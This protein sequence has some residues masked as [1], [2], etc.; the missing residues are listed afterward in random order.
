[1]KP[2][3]QLVLL[4]IACASGA[5]SAAVD[6]WPIDAFGT[7]D[8][9][10]LA[11]IAY[12][13][14]SDGTKARIRSY[15]RDAAKNT[16]AGLIAQGWLSGYDGDTESQLEAYRDCAHRFPT[17]LPCLGNLA[18]T[19]KDPG[20]KQK[21]L[22]AI[23]DQAPEF[24]D[25]TA[26][27]GM[28][29]LLLDDRGDPTAAAALL[30]A[31]EQTNPGHA[32]FDFIRGLQA[33]HS[34]HNNEKAALYFRKAI[35]KRQLR[36][37]EVLRRLIELET[38]PL[39]EGAG[40][41]LALALS[42]VGDY[43][44]AGGGTDRAPLYYLLQRFASGPHTWNQRELILEL[45]WLTTGNKG[46]AEWEPEIL[47]FVEPG[48]WVDHSELA[49]RIS[50]EIEA[51]GHQSGEQLLW[52]SQVAL[53]RDRDFR[54]AARLARTGLADLQTEKQRRTS[55]T[56]LMS[57]FQIMNRCDVA[58]ELAKYFLS[59]Y[60]PSKGFY[61]Q[62]FEV[63]L[64]VG[65]LAEAAASLA[66][67][68]DLGETDNSV[69]RDDEFRLAVARA[70]RKP[71]L[72]PVADRRPAG[73]PSTNALALSP[74]GSMLAIG[75]DPIRLVDTRT[76]NLIGNLGQGTLYRFTPNGQHLVVLGARGLTV[77]ETA[78]G[79]SVG[80][81][82]HTDSQ[83][84]RGFA[85]GPDGQRLVVTDYRG[86]LFRYRLP[87]LELETI[88]QICPSP[89]AAY[90]AWL[91][92]G[93]IVTASATEDLVRRW[94]PETLA[95]RGTL[96]GVDWVHVLEA[97]PSG[98][99]LAAGDNSSVLHIWDTQ[100]SEPW[101]HTA[102]P[103]TFAGQI[104]F[105]PNE[106]RLIANQWNGSGIAVAVSPRGGYPQALPEGINA[107]HAYS[108][109]GLTVYR[110][111]GGLQKL[112][113][114]TLD[115]ILP[116][117]T[118]PAGPA[119]Y[120]SIRA[121]PELGVYAVAQADRTEFRSLTDD[122]WVRTVAARLEPD[123]IAQTP[124]RFAGALAGRYYVYDYAAD[125]LTLATEI[126]GDLDVDSK[127]IVKV[128]KSADIAGQ[129]DVE[130][131]RRGETTAY[132]RAAIP[133]VT[134][135]LQYSRTPNDFGYGSVIDRGGRYWV[136]RTWWQDGFG[137]ETQYS[138]R[139]RVFDLQ[140]GVLV[141]TFDLPEG[142]RRLASDYRK[143]QGVLIKLASSAIPLNVSEQPR[144][145]NALPLGLD[146]QLIWQ[147]PC[148]QKPRAVRKARRRSL[149]LA[150]VANARDRQGDWP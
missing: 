83:N 150:S 101:Q 60:P 108:P 91:K 53:F 45:A 136:L 16:P 112:N 68:K 132:A 48:L 121:Y 139:I 105:S 58:D 7:T 64:C 33:F 134:E 70:E 24:D 12:N 44:A 56:R 76:Q 116:M 147:S 119:D 26:V 73:I 38:G 141:K 46:A 31:Q 19:T 5:V 120:R 69:L 145:E 51:A 137:Y 18:S 96:G 129:V 99:Y 138:K 23:L 62:Y 88:K 87:G 113:A 135:D 90:V 94:D 118:D 54:L 102:Q 127:Y 32:A 149:S 9:D 42:L 100:A 78:T 36:R 28:Y 49:D 85:I 66:H 92:W 93:D 79:R 47:S 11:E 77:R 61:S 2:F 140:T 4:A 143:D 104:A 144:L 71:S 17:A 75:T 57:D 142:V 103:M 6:T 52:T 14:F 86:N 128:G 114:E 89:L 1:M 84:F 39:F 25:F 55:I 125:Q 10:A 107:F 82:L 29:F 111:D 8:P 37:S 34:D 59:K 35:A 50:L 115:P 27:R 20:E 133:A 13:T 67:R 110:A 41:R 3:V 21:A 124:I 123:P 148:L 131:Y 109:D 65:D 81:A 30:A 15:L 72:I 98:R 80:W 117:G 43:Y 146:D 22:Q 122:H 40:D 130:F 95:A 97:S 74:D 106:D 63:N 126:A